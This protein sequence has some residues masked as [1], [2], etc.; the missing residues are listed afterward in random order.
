[1]TAGDHGGNYMNESILNTLKKML[2][3]TEEQ[4]EFDGELIVHINSVIN[5]LHQ[6]GV[7][8]NA[9][10]VYSIDGPAQT[11]VDFLTDISKFSM[12]KSY[13]FLKVKL[14]FDPPLNST[15]I[16]SMERQII[17]FEFRLLENHND[18]KKEDN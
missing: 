16:S 11:W 5:I 10:E 18:F 2:G 1:M 4:T 14:L 9:D 13:M 17:E 3:I 8:N 15:V 12:V 7:F 6:I